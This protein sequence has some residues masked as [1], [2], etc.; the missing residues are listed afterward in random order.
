MYNIYRL[1]ILGRETSVF[2]Y[3][4]N[5]V[6]ILICKIFLRYKREIGGM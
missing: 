5:I 6:F 4:E 1:Q 3:H 2:S